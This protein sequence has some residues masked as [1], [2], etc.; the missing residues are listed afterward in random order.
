MFPVVLNAEVGLEGRGGGRG[1][2]VLQPSSRG[3]CRC[4]RH[5]H[6]AREHQKQFQTCQVL[7]QHSGMQLPEYSY[8]YCRCLQTFDQLTAEE[9]F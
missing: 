8:V 7:C 6:Y 2:Y 4:V 5:L 3:W 9:L 1:G